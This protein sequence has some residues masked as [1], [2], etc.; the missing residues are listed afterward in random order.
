MAGSSSCCSSLAGAAFGTSAGEGEG[1]STL[2]R[3]G[4]DSEFT[5]A[6]SYC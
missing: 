6:G 2:L 1:V 4:L 3:V 5:G